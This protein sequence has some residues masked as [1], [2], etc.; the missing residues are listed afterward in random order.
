M[1]FLCLSFP[2]GTHPNSRLPLRLEDLTQNVA[3][4]AEIVRWR[5]GG[6]GGGGGGFPPPPPRVTSIPADTR[7]MH[8]A[9]TSSKV[10]DGANKTMVISVIPHRRYPLDIL[11]LYP[12]YR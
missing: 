3:L 2:D 10:D 7:D 6:G 11:T 8:L 9:I 4:K 1:F 5:G 12:H